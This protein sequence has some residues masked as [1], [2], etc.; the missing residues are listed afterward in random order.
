MLLQKM[1]KVRNLDFG[2]I[3][4]L[5]KHQIFE[6]V[7]KLFLKSEKK[8]IYSNNAIVCILVCAQDALKEK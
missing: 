1:V 3:S 4:C 8:L 6:L 5:I 2:S 7:K